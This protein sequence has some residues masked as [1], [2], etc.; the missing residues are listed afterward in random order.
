MSLRKRGNQASLSSTAA[1][2][3]VA[4]TVA[5]AQLEDGTEFASIPLDSLSSALVFFSVFLIYFLSAYPSVTGG[6]AGELV[7]VSC[8]LGL[9]HPPGYPTFSML[10]WMA[11]QLLP[12]TSAAFRVNFL[13]LTCGAFAAL[14]IHRA[15]VLITE[16]V[17]PGIFLSF[18]FAFSPTVWLYSI[19][20]EVFSLNN[21]L[22]AFLLYWTVRYFRAEYQLERH[23]RCTAKQKGQTAAPDNVLLTLQN[24]LSLY[25]YI[26]AFACGLAMTNQHTTV[27]FTMPTAALVSLSL[28]LQ[29]LVTASTAIRLTFFLFLGMSPY[30]YLPLRGWFQPADSWGDPR[31]FSGFF[32]HFFRR[33]YGTFQLAA[34][35]IGGATSTLERITVYFRVLSKESLYYVPLLAIVGAV[36]LF[37]YA[38]SPLKHART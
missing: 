8:K 38:Q 35:E 27:F 19:Q 18:L 6:D 4:P 31:T 23:Q 26:G 30:L 7:M 16:S 33:E 22:C 24:R 11:V 32:T 5:P 13:C 12:F 1:A 29:R 36:V 9:A 17:W 15:C 3:A 14:F 37:R 34:T 25:A 28:L 21:L 10:G 2:A 20:G